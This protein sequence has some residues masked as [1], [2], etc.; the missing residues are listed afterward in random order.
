MLTQLPRI[1]ERLK[2]MVIIEANGVGFMGVPFRIPRRRVNPLYVLTALRHDDASPKVPGAM[3]SR[4]ANV[5]DSGLA[6]VY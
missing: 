3:Q 6:N 4:F 5:Q 1:S 2:S